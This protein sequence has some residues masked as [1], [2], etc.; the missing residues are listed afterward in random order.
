MPVAS[1]AELV[2][3]IQIGRHGEVWCETGVGGGG[4]PGQLE[5][6]DQVVPMFGLCVVLWWC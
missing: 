2:F 6:I 5:L 4:D 3:P 1:Q